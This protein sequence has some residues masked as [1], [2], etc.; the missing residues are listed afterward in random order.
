MTH[1]PQPNPSPESRWLRV[2]V[3]QPDL[4]FGHSMPNLHLLRQTID[5][6]VGE[7]ALDL[8]VLPEIFSGDPDSAD[9]SVARQ[10]LQTLARACDVNVIGGS[11]L[12]REANSQQYNTCFAVHRGGELAG[13]YDKRILF[14]SEAE[15]R[16]S[17]DGPLIVEFEGF[18]VGVLICADLWHP[19]LARE[20]CGKIDVLAVVVKSSVPTHEHK[21]YARQNWHAMAL[22]RAMEN[23]FAV[24]VS[25]W[26][27]ARHDH[28]R[29]FKDG[30]RTRH[31]HYTSGASCI[32]DPSHRPDMPR[33]QRMFLKGQPG[34][35]RADLNL[36]A[37]KKFRAYRTS[38]GLLPE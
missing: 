13:R 11:V 1:I 23:G 25:D 27:D 32:V 16:S 12:L 28:E 15:I 30:V 8:V 4:R 18:R 17:G 21:E 35:L 10:F 9:G 33:I 24:L 34:V 20:L 37:L 6:L 38:V 14:S 19:E 2:A 22:T 5:R 29:T 36:D 26:P 7:A 31:T 3:L